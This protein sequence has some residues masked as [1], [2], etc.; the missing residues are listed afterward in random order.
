MNLLPLI[1]VVPL[2]MAIIFSY[3]YRSKYVRSLTLLMALV[4][5]ILPFLG[6]YGPYFFGGHGITFIEGIPLVSGILYTLNPLKEILLFTLMLIGSLVLILSTK[7][8]NLSGVFTSLVLM[9]LA[10]VSAVILTEDLFNLYVFYEIA[11]IAQAGLVILAGTENAYRSA[12][13]YLLVGTMAGS[14][15]LLGVGLLLSATGTLNIGDMGR[16]LALNP[17]TP[18]VY[19]GLLML[20]VGLAYGGGLPPFH[21]LKVDLYARAKPFVSAILQ[22]YSKFVLIALMLV[23]L[24]LFGN[25]PIFNT[26]RGVLIALSVIAMVFG[27][28]M[29]L[30]Q[31]DYRKLLA[32][33]TI[34]QGGYVA[35]GLALGT[36]LGIVAGIF[37]GINHALY[38]S[39][40][41]I[42]AHI[43][44]KVRSSDMRKVGGLLLTIPIVAFLMLFAKFASIGIP[45]FNGFQSKLLLAE[46]VMGA[47]IPE[48]VVLMLIVS[49]GTF[50]YMMKAFYLIFLKPCG[51]EQLKEYRDV[52][53]SKYHIFSLGLLVVLCLILG[54]Y[55]DIV[56]DRLYPIGEE[57][58]ISWVLR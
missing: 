48:L 8:K 29:A 21:T 43:V 3:I 22:T 28:V 9:G 52:K 12:F 24:K 50:L 46:A 39:A 14:I 34:S 26:I 38:K 36:P 41:F 19:G 51:E 32:Y 49:I 11:A 30:L 58:G 13:K 4:L 55:P 17:L 15:L 37:H 6:T 47:N 42:G 1:V 40:L 25:L 23:I 5:L 16:Y 57:I 45:P 27:T 35:L 20:I 31:E 53:I 7:E 10:S 33:H 2:I 18:T 56:L 44:D 54:V